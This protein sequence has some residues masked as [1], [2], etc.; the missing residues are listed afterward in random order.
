MLISDSYQTPS[1]RDI[2]PG[3]SSFL[4][5]IYQIILFL[6]IL[7]CTNKFQVN[8]NLTECDDSVIYRHSKL[9]SRYTFI[10]MRLTIKCN[11]QWGYLT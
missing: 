8:D 3:S 7:I 6:Y 10:L 5:N 9:L 2:L 1:L 4:S 11:W